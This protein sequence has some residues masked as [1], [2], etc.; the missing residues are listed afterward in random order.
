MNKFIKEN[1]FKIIIS[2]SVL[3]VALSVGNF[4]LFYL[5]N[6]NTSTSTKENNEKIIK[7]QE[8]K[9]KN[10]ISG[11]DDEFFK[12]QRCPD[13]KKEIE[14]EINDYNTS[15]VNATKLLGKIYYSHLKNTCIYTTTTWTPKNTFKEG[16]KFIEYDAVDM[17]TGENIL[18]TNIDISSEQGERR[19]NKEADFNKAVQELVK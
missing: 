1:I 13:G 6:K 11:D 19:M 4:Y 17:L 15:G 16:L 8:E 10:K 18:Y 2:F 5:P 3:F 14:K 9:T 7:E 12:K